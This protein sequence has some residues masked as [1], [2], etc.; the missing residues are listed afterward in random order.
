MRK[1]AWGPDDTHRVTISEKPVDGAVV[2]TN[3][4]LSKTVVALNEDFDARLF[5]SNTTGGTVSYKAIGAYFG[6]FDPETGICPDCWGWTGV[7]NIPPGDSEWVIPCSGLQYGVWDV[8]GCIGE[9]VGGT[10]YPEQLVYRLDYL[11]VS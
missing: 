8:L 6:N 11:T 10:F 4:T 1:L 5:I 2:V 7:P 9:L 3:I